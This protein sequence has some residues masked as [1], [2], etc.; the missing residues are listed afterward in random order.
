[1]ELDPRA[2]HAREGGQAAFGKVRVPSETWLAFAR[3]VGGGHKVG[4]FFALASLANRAEP[5]QVEILFSKFKKTIHAKDGYLAGSKSFVRCHLRASIATV[6]RCPSPAHPSPL[7]VAGNPVAAKLING[8]IILFICNWH[9]LI[10]SLL[11]RQRRKPRA[12]PPRHR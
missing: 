9:A 8:K 2:L 12:P 3:C 4:C 10:S 6:P 7:L 5:Q 11:V 1:M